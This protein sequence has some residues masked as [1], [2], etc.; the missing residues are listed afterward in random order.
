MKSHK[1]VGRSDQPHFTPEEIDAYRV[2]VTSK[3]KL[4]VGD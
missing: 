3:S 2:L 4:L 1:V